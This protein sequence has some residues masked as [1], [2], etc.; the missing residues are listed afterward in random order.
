[1]AE[2]LER[3]LRKL[4]LSYALL[5]IQVYYP[6]LND[7]RSDRDLYCSGYRRELILAISRGDNMSINFLVFVFVCY[8]KEM[9]SFDTLGTR[10]PV[11]PN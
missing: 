4:S 10:I 11:L 3:M 8:A 7:C 1:M 6:S 9:N 5:C 2:G